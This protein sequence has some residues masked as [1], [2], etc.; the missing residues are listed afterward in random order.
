MPIIHKKSAADAYLDA[1]DGT[2]APIPTAAPSL[3]GVS[4]ADAFLDAPD[5]GA[6][7]IVTSVKPPEQHGPVRRFLGSLAE[8]INPITAVKGI[9]Q[10]TAHPVDTYNADAAARTG[11][12]NEARQ[13]FGRGDVASGIA[14]GVE[15]FIPFLGTAMSQAGD[16]FESGDI[17]GA[18]GTSVGMG[19]AM[20]G[21]SK[22][23][24]VP[25][26]GRGILQGGAR[27]LQQSALKPA[28]KGIVQRGRIID[29]TL[30]E[31]LTPGSEGIDAA[32]AGLSESGQG[33]SN[34]TSSGPQTQS[35]SPGSV[36]SEL[37][38][39]KQP[40]LGV[41]LSAIEAVENEFLDRFRSSPTSAVRNM[42]PAEA[43]G[44]K[45]EA[46][47]AAT[48]LK[49]AAYEPG[50][51]PNTGKV[52]AYQVIADMLGDQLLSQFP[53]LSTPYARYSA[54]KEAMPAVQA[55]AK[56]IGNRNPFGPLSIFSGVATGVMTG[57]LEHGVLAG[58]M[59]ELLTNPVLR[60]KL[61][62]S[63]YRASNGAMT[64][65]AASARVAAYAN[66]LGQA[67]AA[68]YGGPQ[69]GPAGQK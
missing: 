44:L 34:I 22:L 62:V 19:L 66:A 36:V 6:A 7:G 33:I 10:L 43:Q 37:G 58:A 18:A 64:I 15:S 68:E 39:L 51:Q 69:N 54:L 12:F 56:R 61:A 13:R 55:A 35:I 14:K 30:R 21:P 47:Q 45:T 3:G 46:Q 40:K 67:V 63:M 4:A 2:P 23:G 60:S 25:I 50:G 29:T 8:Q 5:T 1:P 27:A 32:R 48:R 20:A 24:D 28:A 31:G 52:E 65:P 49:K 38:K 57:G 17:A 41:D 42:T 26:P 11:I 53:E 9:A 59:A 16:R